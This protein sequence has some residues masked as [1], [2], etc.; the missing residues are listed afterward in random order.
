MVFIDEFDRLAV[1]EARL[2]F[3][4]TI[5]SLSDRVP[6]V[7]V[8]LVGVADDVTELIEEHRSVERALRS[9]HM[10]RMSPDEL[11]E[12]VERGIA[13]ARLTIAPEAVGEIAS[14]ADGF[15]HYAHLLGQESGRIALEDLRT[16]VSREDVR[17]AASEAFGSPAKL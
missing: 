1:R 13:T 9:I 3:A 4:D 6:S 15:P 14:L 16:H 7:T 12:I 5:K 8:V 11:S 17:T 10:P 2:L